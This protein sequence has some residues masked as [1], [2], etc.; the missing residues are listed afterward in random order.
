MDPVPDRRVEYRYKSTLSPVAFKSRMPNESS[1]CAMRE[2][3]PSEALKSKAIFQST[4]GEATLEPL[5]SKTL[6]DKVRGVSPKRALDNQASNGLVPLESSGEMTNLGSA[7][8]L[9]R[10]VRESL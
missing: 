4:T 3:F 1:S 9:S 6:A 7:T 10:S 2:L 8:Y 5:L